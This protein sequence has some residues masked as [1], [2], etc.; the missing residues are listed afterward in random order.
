MVF[1]R[2]SVNDKEAFESNAENF[3][4][5]FNVIS[6]FEEEPVTIDNLEDFI[7]FEW[8]QVIF[9]GPYVTKAFIYEVV[10]MEWT[11]DITTGISEGMNQAVFLDGGRVVCHIDGYPEQYKVFFE[12]NTNHGYRAIDREDDFTFEVKR[13]QGIY[14]LKYI[15]KN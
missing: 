10:G 6:F 3:Q 13:V 8:D 4:E 11:N 1:G 14:N 9:F 2:F 7:P 12:I 15:G 5:S